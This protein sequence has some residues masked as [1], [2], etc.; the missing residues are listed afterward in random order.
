MIPKNATLPIALEY[1][2]KHGTRE[3]CFTFE[4]GPDTWLQ[5]TTEHIN[6]A[7]YAKAYVPDLKGLKE[8]ARGDSYITWKYDSE[9]LESVAM[10]VRHYLAQNLDWQIGMTIAKHETLDRSAPS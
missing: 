9:D 6:A 1:L 8:V 7:F 4:S 2:K 10:N 5:L 3:D